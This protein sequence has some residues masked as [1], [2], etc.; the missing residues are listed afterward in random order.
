[1]ESIL[2]SSWH[3]DVTVQDSHVRQVRPFL[4][5]SSYSVSEWAESNSVQQFH[6]NPRSSEGG[7]GFGSE[8]VTED[9]TEIG[10]AAPSLPSQVGRVH[11]VSR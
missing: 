1:M 10:R 2:S 7:G 5:R 9:L 3:D 4:D 11:L 6:R 8:D